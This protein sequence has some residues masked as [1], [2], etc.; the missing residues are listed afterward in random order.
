MKIVR[1]SATGPGDCEDG[2]R[3][4]VS[5]TDRGTPVVRG[6]VPDPSATR[7]LTLPTGEGAVAVPAAPVLEAARQGKASR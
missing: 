7:Q 1:K 5:V 2:D 3:P 6:S 4:A